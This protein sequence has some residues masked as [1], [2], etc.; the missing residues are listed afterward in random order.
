MANAAFDNN[1]SNGSTIPDTPRGW[2]L[3]CSAPEQKEVEK[4]VDCFAKMTRQNQELLVQ[5]NED[6][7]RNRR[8]ARWQEEVNNGNQTRPSAK[9]LML[10][11]EAA[12]HELMKLDRLLKSGRISGDDFEARRCDVK[13]SYTAIS[14]EIRKSF[15]FREQA[16][17]AKRDL[18]VLAQQAVSTIA[19]LFPWSDGIMCST[20]PTYTDLNQMM[21]RRTVEIG[22]SGNVLMLSLA[23]SQIISKCK[24][25]ES[26]KKRSARMKQP[27]LSGEMF[28]P[29]G[30][31]AVYGSRE[32]DCLTW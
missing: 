19:A 9:A 10:V 26:E 23:A 28:A 30:E 27:S 5:A 20:L 31:K 32:L 25:E 29:L 24:I 15:A 1:S 17:C 22:L 2:L 16:G 8:V 13:R 4:P 12:R 18:A 14:Q 3:K 21:E 7:I 11:G 6:D